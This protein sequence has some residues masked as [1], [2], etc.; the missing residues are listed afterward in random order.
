MLNFKINQK[1][2]GARSLHV[3]SEAEQKMLSQFYHDWKAAGVTRIWM[4]I[5][6]LATQKPSQGC[7][8]DD[9]MYG[10]K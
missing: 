7:R 8:A 2:I 10:H 9:F 3:E 6:D 1:A 4:E 5:S